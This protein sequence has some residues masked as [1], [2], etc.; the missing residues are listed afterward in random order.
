M[1]K[2][3]KYKPNTFDFNYSAVKLTNFEKKEAWKP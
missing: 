1:G 2:R 3:P